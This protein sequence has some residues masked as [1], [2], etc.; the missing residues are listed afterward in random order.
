MLTFQFVLLVHILTYKVFIV[1]GSIV[2]FIKRCNKKGILMLFKY[3]FL[4]SIFHIIVSIFY[5][6]LSLL[7]ILFFYFIS[8]DS[9]LFDSTLFFWINA[10]FELKIWMPPFFIL[11]G[12]FFQNSLFVITL[13]FIEPI[14][15]LYYNS[16]LIKFNKNHLSF[17]KPYLERLPYFEL[18]KDQIFFIS[19]I[20]Q[21]TIIVG[22]IQNSLIL[23]LV[24][25]DI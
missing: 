11:F 10:I 4:I 17:T 1:V 13:F 3:F 7:F 16:R 5:F 25:I 9:T 2:F 15:F 19:W 24:L 8:F 22:L 20:R 23:K 14:L 18:K 12:I 6:I 21:T